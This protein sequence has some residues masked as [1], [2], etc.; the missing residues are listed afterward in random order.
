MINKSIISLALLCSLFVSA[1]IQAEPQEIDHVTVIVNEG[2]ILESEIQAIIAEV[3]KTALQNNQSLPSDKALRAQSVDRLI[4]NSVQVQM[5]ENMGIQISD[6]HLDSVIQN[7][8]QSQN[9]TVEQVRLEIVKSGESYERYREKLR[10]EVALNEVRRGNVHRRVNISLQEINTLIALMD[11]NS[12]KEE[13][14]IGH[15][16][17]SVPNKAAQSEVD[18][19]KEIANKVLKLLKDGS[20][21][22]KIAIASSSGAKALEGG[23]WGYMG[24]NEMP[25]LFAES[26][27]DK[28]A[29]TLIGPLRSGAGF[30]IVKI[31]DVRGRQTVE[32]KEVLARHILIKPSIILSEEKAKNMLNKFLEEV[33]DGTED[34]GKLAKKHSEDPGS[35]LKNGELGWANPDIYAPKFKEQLASLKVG[36]YSKPFRSQFGW[37]VVQLM[38]ERTADATAKS[39]QDQAYQILYKRKFAEEAENWLREIRDQAYIEVIAE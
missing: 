12:S 15:I 29:G 3:K 2:V 33:A 5:A 18:V 39:K 21:F 13:Y 31:L 20:D 8:A 22:K 10:E 6:A 17:V 23:D 26:V 9:M 35:A 4:I 37:H 7:I 27:R 19:K 34:F 24:I 14:Q 1:T 38:E 36:E 30:H 11:E 16:L 25:S 32:V 28:K